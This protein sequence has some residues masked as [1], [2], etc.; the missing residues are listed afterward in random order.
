VGLLRPN[1]QT[2]IPSPPQIPEEEVHLYYDELRE[3]ISTIRDFAV[4]GLFSAHAPKEIFPDVHF[5]L[6][7]SCRNA[8]V[9]IID[10]ERHDVHCTIKYFSAE[11]KNKS[12]RRAKLWTFA[13]SH[14]PSGRTMKMGPSRKMAVYKSSALSSIIGCK[15]AKKNNWECRPNLCFSCNNLSKFDKYSDG[16]NNWNSFYEALVVFPLRYEAEKDGQLSE[17]IMGFM[18]FDSPIRGV[19]RGIPSRFEYIGEPEKYM[20]DLRKTD[21]YHVGHALADAVTM[22]TYLS[23]PLP[24]RAIMYLN[25]DS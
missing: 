3:A 14:G 4:R 20:A 7:N 9:K 5:D 1:Q 12:K 16:K 11:K 13:R 15:D 23:T 18:T 8:M 25:G 22:G 19:F 21:V 24:E 10:C 2:G 17:F 6:A